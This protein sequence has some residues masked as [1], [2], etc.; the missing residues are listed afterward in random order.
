M[1]DKR[2]TESPESRSRD[3]EDVSSTRYPSCSRNRAAPRRT[4]HKGLAMITAFPTFSPAHS[5][6]SPVFAYYEEYFD[7]REFFWR[8]PGR[9]SRLFFPALAA[10]V[11]HFR[12]LER[13]GGDVRE[14]GEQVQVLLGKSVRAVVIEVQDADDFGPPLDR[15]RQLRPHLRIR[16]HVPGI[17]LHVAAERRLALLAHPPGDPFPDPEEDLLLD[18]R[19]EAPLGLDPQNAG[20]PVD[21]GHGAAGGSHQLRGRGE[22][23]PSA[24]TIPEGPRMG[25]ARTP[26]TS[27]RRMRRKSLLSGPSRASETIIPSPL[28]MIWAK[29]LSWTSWRYFSNCL[30]RGR[31]LPGGGREF[32]PEDRLVEKGED[33]H[34][35][36]SSFRTVVFNSFVSWDFTM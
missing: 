25:A 4:V 35:P 5:P 33:R 12:V 3:Q 6:K 9:P 27:R 8:R 28:A 19:P 32:L 18:L 29:T 17:L 7:R 15:D 21:E 23:A 24:P 16:L 34:F 14:G 30:P 20:R 1:P 10:P 13:H 11:E 31:N 36:P 2:L 26:L 22:A